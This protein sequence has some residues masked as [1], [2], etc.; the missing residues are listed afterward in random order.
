MP[1]SLRPG[2]L[3]ALRP[4]PF[5]IILACSGTASAETSPYYIGVSQSFT[6]QDNVFRRPD[7]VPGA[8]IVSDTISSTGV[9]GGIDQPFGRQRFFASG[10]AAVNK[11]KNQSQLDNNS[12]GLTAGLDWSTIERLSGTVRLNANRSLASY[13]DDGSSSTTQRNIQTSHQ[14]SLSARYGLGANIGLEGGA[15]ARKVKFSASDDQ[16][17]FKQDSANLG[18]RWGGSG[19]LSI[20]LSGRTSKGTYPN[21]QTASTPTPVFETDEVDRQDLSVNVTWTPTGLSTISGRLSQT[22]EEHS[23]PFRPEFKGTTGELSWDY[24]LT[25]KVGMRASF[26]RDTGTETTFRQV[27]LPG[28]LPIPV[29]GLDPIRVDSNRLS[30]SWLLNMD[31]ELTAKIHMA[32]NARQVKSSAGGSTGSVTSYGLSASYAPTRTISI[33]CNV[34][35]DERSGV[36]DA[37]SYG[38]SARLTLQ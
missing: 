32:A 26:V 17:G 18:V 12:Y 22:R 9:N 14:A 8:P 38:C 6:H 2:A 1:H 31:Y 11:H 10:N 36:Y 33:G 24:R 4:L 7:G 25:G 23:L 20:G 3:A 27:F 21:I 34:N 15:E 35:R 29:P 37:N 16:R 19:Q 30:N 5:A 28:P 13:G